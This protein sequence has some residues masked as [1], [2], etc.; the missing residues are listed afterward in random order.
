VRTIVSLAHNLGMEVIAEGVESQEQA[1]RLL[2]LGCEYG[3][4]YYFSR[5]VEAE[6]ASARLAAP[7]AVPA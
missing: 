3:Q 6:A 4:G 5:P 2:G 7:D 1:D